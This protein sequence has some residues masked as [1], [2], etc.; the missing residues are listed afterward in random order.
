MTTSQSPL[1]KIKAQADEIAKMLKAAERGDP[2]DH[3]STRATIAK[4][5]A[6]A[7]NTKTEIK[8]GIAMDDKF[9]SIDITWAVIRATSEAA[10]SEYII[11]QMRAT[12]K[13]DPKVHH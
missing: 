11:K 6:D 9:I 5:F 13:N 7:R 8:V 12:S 2:I 4:G 3:M 1:S 10:L